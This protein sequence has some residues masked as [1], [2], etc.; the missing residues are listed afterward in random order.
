M[1]EGK[2]S[3][4][5]VLEI[6]QVSALNDKGVLALDNISLSLR[7]GEILGL[8]GV[9]GNGQTE[10]AEILTGMRKVT[11]GKVLVQGSD[12][13]NASPREMIKH[14]VGQIPEDRMGSG[15]GARHVHSGKPCPRGE[16]RTEI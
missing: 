13:T 12:L 6:R 3:E 5:A 10:L 8:A 1:L 2:P 7:A 9:A 15:L 16:E 14:G 11:S 4:K